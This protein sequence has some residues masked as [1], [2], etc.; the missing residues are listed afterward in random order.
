MNAVEIIEAAIAKL[1]EQRQ[2][3]MKGPWRPVALNHY[4]TPTPGVWAEGEDEEVG[5]PLNQTDADLLVTLHATIDAQLAILRSAA[6]QFKDSDRLSFHDEPN[7]S[8]LAL[9]LASAILGE[10]PND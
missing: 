3:A 5:Y 10:Q 9:T 8:Q 7:A 6:D 4:G 2:S 1:S